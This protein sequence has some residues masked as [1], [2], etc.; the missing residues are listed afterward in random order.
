MSEL[1]G[2]L[3]RPVPVGELV[4]LAQAR[5]PEPGDE[6]LPQ[7]A[8]FVLSSFNPLIVAVADRCLRRWHGEPP[9]PRGRRTA[10][11]VVSAS[12]DLASAEHVA[13]TVD[14]SQRLGPL[15]FFQSVPNSIAGY[16]AARW[17]LGGPVVCLC[18]T[19]DPMADGMAE[20][21]LLMADGDADEALVVLVE[22]GR[23]DGE[24]RAAAVLV[25]PGGLAEAQLN[26]SEGVGN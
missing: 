22:L 18:P 1:V 7:V 23:D 9:A 19:G 3:P 24:D 4:V 14:A 5:W 11:V 25:R 6:Q 15:F 20:A 16:V 12:G 26:E 17:E 10:V 2:E 21:V 8:G 13:R